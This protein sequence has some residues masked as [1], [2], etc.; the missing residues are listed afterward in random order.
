MSVAA[1]LGLFRVED[2]GAP[3]EVVRRRG[4]WLYGVFAEWTSRTPSLT[5]T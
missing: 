3:K 1:G 2:V 5:L 4:R